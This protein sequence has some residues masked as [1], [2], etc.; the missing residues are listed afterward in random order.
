LG[1]DGQV[2]S[3]TIAQKAAFIMKYARIT[4]NKD[5][6]DI[7]LKALEALNQFVVPHGAQGWECPLASPDILA[8]GYGAQANLDAYLITNNP[9][10]LEKAVYWAKTGIVFHYLW[11]HDDT[12]LQ[13]YATIP[14][15]GATFYTHTWRG[16]P[17]Q[18]CGL[19]Y[20][21]ALQHLAGYDQ[22][23]DWQQL[24]TGI[25]NSALLQQETDGEYAGTLPDSFG[26]YFKT[27]KPAFINPE[28]ILT[29]LHELKGNGFSVNTVFVGDQSNDTM[30]V[31]GIGE[32]T[33]VVMN[34][35]LLSFRF[36]P[37]HE[38]DSEVLITPVTS[39]PQ[40]I[41]I[42]E[43]VIEVKEK[44]FG[45]EMGW[46]YLDERQALLVHSGSHDNEIVLNI[47]F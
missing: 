8:S 37:R 1:K 29:N 30:R 28:N 4:G 7:G 38:R 46:K 20:A 23:F 39:K 19:V 34:D 18:W 6:T 45:E 26:D 14:I 22:S 5:A 31:N 43:I 40:S 36:K 41:K 25:V 11:T 2:A 16:V 21:Y 27:P 33:D 32:F 10:Y 24:A 12:P 17:V 44:L 15:F 9:S 47:E 13:R 35:G 3:G 42:G